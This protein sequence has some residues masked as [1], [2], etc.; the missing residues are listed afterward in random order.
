MITADPLNKHQP[1]KLIIFDCDGVLVDS[2]ILSKRVLLSMLGD[3][4][5]NLSDDYYYTHFLGYNFEHVTAKVLADFSVILT[6]EFR[7]NYRQALVNVFSIELKKT[8]DLEWLL[9]QLNVSTCVATSGSPEKVKNSLNHTKLEEYF[10]GTV[11]TSSEVKHG[12]PA[13]DLFLH[14]AAKMGVSPEN[15]L[16]I[17][18]SETGIK[19]AL[20]ANM[21]V[22]RYAGASHMQNLNTS[23]INS[24]ASVNTIE[25]WK[26]L[27]E[28]EPS[29]CS[30]LKN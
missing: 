14:A 13:P 21:R 10:T 2:E 20:A 7:Q 28:L 8:T 19:A 3:L 11:F 24:S 29:L 25:H 9:P 22:I 27:F 30:S 1:I 18:D 23:P 6:N 5:V 26:Q 12:K 4:G 16:V 15:C 17:E